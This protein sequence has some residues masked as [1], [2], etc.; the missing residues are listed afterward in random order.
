M[1]YH[2]F[3]RPRA[4][5]PFQIQWQEG[6]IAFL[7]HSGT[8]KPED[9]ADLIASRYVPEA[10]TCHP[11]ILLA[12][13][14][15]KTIVTPVSAFRTEEQHFLPP[16]AQ[17]W[18]RK[19]QRDHF[20]AFVGSQLPSDL[21]AALRLADPSMRMPKPKASWVYLE[22]FFCV[23]L[24]VLGWFNKSPTLLRVHADS[25]RQ[26]KQDIKQA[27][28]R[29]YRE[30]GVRLVGSSAASGPAPVQSSPPAPSTTA[31]SLAS[32]PTN[33]PARD[34]AL[35]QAGARL[36]SS[37]AATST[38]PTFTKPPAP[39][40]GTSTARLVTSW[41]RVAGTYS[42]FAPQHFS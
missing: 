17:R 42:S 12:V 31:T 24:S 39:T 27:V 11:V 16:W 29:Q 36:T 25:I 26:L 7:R 13:S 35:T 8:F 41:A 15:S 4:P 32:V 18:H 30:A 1:S 3:C 10:A 22:S 2:N 40:M 23:P 20:R 34:G 9:Y 5:I 33:T 38:A 14:G 28:P 21:H 37:V 6:D 19:K